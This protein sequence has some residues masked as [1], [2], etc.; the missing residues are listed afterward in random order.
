MNIHEF[1]A[2]NPR[3]LV[4]IHPSIVM[5]DYFD[6]VIPLLER[7]YHLYVPALP[8]YDPDD[9]GD[10]TSIEAV[11]EELENF[12]ISRGHLEISCIYGCSMGGSVVI[13]MLANGRVRIRSAAIDG[14][15]TPYS[16][17]WIV[18]RFIALRD[19]L[20][21]YAGKFCGV[22]LLRRAFSTDD[23]TEEDIRYIKRMLDR[24]SA[25]TIWR[26]F[27]S[28]NNYKMPAVVHTDCENIEYWF[29]DA[30]EKARKWDIDY[31]KRQFPGTKFIKMKAL[32][33]GGLA[34]LRPEEFVQNIERLTGI[35]QKERRE[36]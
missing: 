17:P 25:K 11:A 32:G 28:C 15:I 33:H 18:T 2:G 16:L 36:V 23:Y 9:A 34:V 20:T 14:G 30:E 21:V 5:W 6:F 24:S 27:D 19:F 8:G 22:G 35:L 12:L 3:V 13:R 1:G 26:T 10:F 4:L 31:V 29:A 7:N